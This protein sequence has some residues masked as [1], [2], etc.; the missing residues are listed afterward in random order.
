MT[1]G[2]HE[3]A[4]PAGLELSLRRSRTRA[5]STCARKGLA[6]RAGTPIADRAQPSATLTAPEGTQLYLFEKGAQ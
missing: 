1:L 5:A 4:L 6:A 3:D 2:L